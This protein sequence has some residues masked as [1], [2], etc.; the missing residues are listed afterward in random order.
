MRI[1]TSAPFIIYCDF[2]YVLIPSTGIID[3]SP[4]TKKYHDHI[5]CSY[6]YKLTCADKRD[7]K[8]YKIYFCKYVIGNFFNDMIKG[9]EYCFKETERAFNKVFVMTGKDKKDFKILLNVAFVKRHKKKVKL[10]SKIL[11]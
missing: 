11:L 8:P 3:S 10:K 5:V 6:G 1:L 9:S 2:K 7:S 4:S